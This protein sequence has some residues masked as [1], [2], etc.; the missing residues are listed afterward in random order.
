MRFLICAVA[1]G[2]CSIPS[3]ERSTGDGGVGGD[4]ASIGDGNSGDG[5]TTGTDGGTM[6]PPLVL[7]VTSEPPQLG[8][9]STVT[10]AF[11]ANQPATLECRIDAAAYTLC[12]GPTQMFSNLVDGAHTFDLRG[13]AGTETASVPTY[14]FSI[15]TSGPALALTSKP[16]PDS[17]VSAPTFAF[18]TGDATAAS[19]TC[20]IDS[21]NPQACS[22]P[23]PAP[24]LADGQH[25]F[26]L[27]GTDSLGN[28][29][30]TS[31]TWMIDTVAPV[32]T[33]GQVP[34]PYSN[35][36][37]PVFTFSTTEGVTYCSFDSATPSPCTSGNAFG[38]F[39]DG[40]HTLQVS[41]TDGAGNT[42]KTSDFIWTVDATGPIVTTPVADCTSGLEVTW[43]A[44][45][46]T[47]SVASCTCTY[48]G[49]TES[50]TT[51]SWHG[52]GTG[53]LSTFFVYCTDIVGNNSVTKTLKFNS[54]VVCGD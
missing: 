9:Q 2:A 39:A 44:T 21:G 36:R 24:A 46:A 22:S 51:S 26:T 41:A 10:F 18:T 17:N 14:S 3:K 12:P 1:L 11:S 32:V 37:S 34:P 5:G 30:T 25:G 48:P 38:P 45:D 52:V 31:Y 16:V 20:Q 47:T 29:S 4:D 54:A 53:V 13:T 8:N 33:L 35:V 23:F 19:I 40:A 27:R 49:T 6:Q 43:S 50:C 15:D 42:G 28:S 7:Q